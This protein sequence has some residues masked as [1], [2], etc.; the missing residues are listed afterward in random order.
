MEFNCQTCNK[1]YKN[2]QSLWNHKRRIHKEQQ[3]NIIDKVKVYMCK[4]CH[5][6]F[7]RKDTLYKHNKTPCESAIIDTTQEKQQLE[8]QIIELQQKVESLKGHVNNSNNIMNN[9]HNNYGTINNIYINKPGTENILEL[10][11]K[12]ITEI[13]DKELTCVTTL[14]KFINFNERL[15]HN[16]SF[17]AKSL[18]GKYLLTYDTEESKIVSTR[19]KYF[20]QE[21]LENSVSKM[22]LLYKTHKT[23]LSKEKRQTVEHNIE[24][25][26]EI[27][28]S[29]FSNK[30]L[31]EI[32]NKLIEISYNCKNTVL[33]TWNNPDNKVEGKQSKFAKTDEE[34]LKELAECDTGPE[35][36]TRTSDSDDNS[37]SDDESSDYDLPKFSLNKKTKEIIL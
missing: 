11:E 7:V 33:N 22:E 27:K 3:I 20:Y 35:R 30:I 32:K 8:K 6:K 18:E 29:D 26:K 9:S 19:K 2:Y 16:H 25:L 17:C 1:N 4:N 13:F 24:R 36:I 31:K 21:I 15:P 28:D 37:S 14:I 34:I 5:K 23:K 12:E 10:N